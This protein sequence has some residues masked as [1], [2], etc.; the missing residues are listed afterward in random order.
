V[1][2]LF[3]VRTV[4]PARWIYGSAWVA[5]LGFYLA[6]IQ[7]M[8]VADPMMYFTWIGLA[9]YCSLFVPL[10]VYLIRCLDRR[11]G[12]PL[13]VSVPVVWTALEF[14]RAHFSTGFPW[15]FLS[16]TQHDLLAVIQVSDLAGAY[17]VTFLIAAVNAM[18][19][20]ILF[21]ASWFRRLTDGRADFR[22]GSSG[23]RQ[24]LLQATG[25]GLLLVASVMY[26]TWRLGQENSESGPRV[27]LLQG[28]LDQ[29]IRNAAS[30]A[31][32]D[33]AI[34]TVLEH[35]LQLSDKAACQSPK[36]DLIVWPETSFPQKWVEVDPALSSELVPEILRRDELASQR[37]ARFAAQR[38]QTHTLLGMP[39]EIV[40]ADQRGRRY[41]SAI[42]IEPQGGVG[43]RYD[44]M[45]L[46][47]FGEYVPFR[48]WLPWMNV[49]A[50]YDFDYSVES[51]ERWTRFPVGEYHFGVL[52]CY[53][54]TDPSLA[55][56]YAQGGADG[57]G[58]DFLINI[59][60]DGWF[61]G[62]SEHE[63]HLAICRF[64]AIES[65]RA[66]A[67]AVNMGISAVIDGN[68][69]VLALPGPSWAQSKKISAV[70]TAS[71]PMDRRTSLYSR[72]GDWLPWSCWLVLVLGLVSGLIRQVRPV[73]IVTA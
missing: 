15:Y 70:V 3:L 46:V 2:V 72:W 12:L 28:N 22:F 24:L 48:S 51:G 59:S 18:A 47:P 13:V 33:E 43:G 29:R 37:L 67:R 20:E 19:F 6:A 56:Q 1:P 62:T 55:R 40:G 36:P 69:R 45:H 52:I 10:G 16:H 31:E 41:N 27:A 71:I 65:R 32:Q 34:K 49:F 50:P 30:D 35:F 58:A 17:A 7:W 14:F 5:G 63:E 9:I 26:G 54:D 64:R 4:A 60:N 61:N 39:S 38:W 68:G 11:T 66:I 73:G 23:P 44:K 8:R 25:V 53:E 42:L 21:A 57:P